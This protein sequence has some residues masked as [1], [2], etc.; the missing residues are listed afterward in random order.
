[1]ELR[2]DEIEALLKFDGA[3]LFVPETHDMNVSHIA[4]IRLPAVEVG[5]QNRWLSGS[6]ETRIEAI[7]AVWEVYQKYMATPMASRHNGYWLYEQA[8]ADVQRQRL[9]LNQEI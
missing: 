1:M 5:I 4:L 8:T 2:E 7:H 6:G 9:K 3:V